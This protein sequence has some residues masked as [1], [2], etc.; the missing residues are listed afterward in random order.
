LVKTALDEAMAIDGALGACLV[1][2]SSGMCLGTAGGQG[3]NL[4]VAAACNTE[5]V[6]AQMR[7]MSQ[8]GLRDRIEDLLITL[9][10]QYH[11]IRMVNGASSLFLYVALNKASTTLAMARLQLAQLEQK[12]AA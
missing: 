5:V 11:L 1:D 2:C 4:E 7:T 8:L 6:K 12:I 10:S 3:L 9:G